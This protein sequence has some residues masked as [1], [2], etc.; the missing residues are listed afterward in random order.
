MLALVRASAHPAADAAPRT[1]PDQAM[2][3][4][5][6]RLAIP[7]AMACAVAAIVIGERRSPLRSRTQPGPQRIVTNLVL[8]AMSMAVVAAVEG[9]LVRH[10]AD[11]ASNRRRGLA[12]AA[13][14]P[15]W[16]RDG[17]AVLGMDYTIYL[18]H[19]LT[20]KVP[21]LWRLHLIH[22]MDLD[23]DASTALRFHAVDM[24]VSVPY[25]AA[26]VALLGVSARALRVWQGF[27]FLSVLFHH[28]N[29]RLPGQL[30]RRLSWLLT[31]PRMHGI[32][33]STRPEETGSNWSSGLS[34][35]DRL[36]HTFRIDVPQR[37]IHIGVP[38][39]RDP[40]ETHVWPSLQRPFRP[41]R[42]AWTPAGRAY[43]DH[44][45]QGCVDRI[46]GT[47]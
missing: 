33:H 35:W 9:P 4:D 26:Q 28:S 2:R 42:D 40:A 37:R 16:A 25:R 6:T 13:P 17:L 45:T 8:G 20:H 22:H 29:L 14:L 43:D 47:V 15:A 27:F 12:Q 18:W 19:I 46:A 44:V 39:F 31:T 23:L 10:L 3:P 11:Q 1:P 34:L 32:H 36:H 7:A 30:D 24:L 21:A 38:A 41:Q 5:L